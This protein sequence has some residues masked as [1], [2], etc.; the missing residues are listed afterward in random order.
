M[1]YGCTRTIR[2]R[3]SNRRGAA[4]LLA[5]YF[6]SLMF[7]LLGGV[8]LQRTMTETK[9]AYLSRDAHQSFWSA[10][11]AFDQAL[12]ALRANE[13]PAFDALGCTYQTIQFDKSIDARGNYM[14]CRT[15]NPEQFQVDMLGTSAT[16]SPVWLTSFIERKAPQVT[17]THAL[18]GLD[19]L[20]LSHATV[21]GLNTNT[22]PIALSASSLA[23][24]LFDGYTPKLIGT[25]NNQGHIA[26]KA[27]TREA[28]K[29][30]NN[31]NILGKILTG[32]AGVSMIS[33]DSRNQD[34]SVAGSVSNTLVDFPSVKTPETVPTLGDV[35]LAN[36]DTRPYTVVSATGAVTLENAWAVVAP[37]VYRTNGLIL[38]DASLSTNG[39]VD[40]YVK[41]S[42]TVTRSLLY[43]QALC[44]GQVPCPESEVNRLKFSPPNLRIYVQPV[45]ASDKVRVTKGAVVA[46]ILYAPQ[47]P[48]RIDRK[49][50]LM[51]AMVSKTAHIG[52]MPDEPFSYTE[53]AADKTQ[54]Y[55]DQAVG[56]QPISPSLDSPAAKVL[57]YSVHKSLAEASA[58]TGQDQNRV[59]KWFQF[60]NLIAPIVAA[61]AARSSP[62]SSGV[63]SGGGCGGGGGTIICTELHR[64]GYLSDARFAADTAY[65]KTYLDS[66]TWIGY[67][68]WAQYVA[69]GMRRSAFV[70]AL[71]RPFGLAWAQHMAFVMGEST[72][73]NLLGRVINDVGIPL[74]RAFGKYLVSL[75]RPPTQC[76]VP[77]A[78][79]WPEASAYHTYQF[80]SATNYSAWAQW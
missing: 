22:A 39:P 2:H 27:M 15:T 50:L 65:G 31:S 7:L 38:T 10:E 69:A 70:T 61:P 57:Y 44:P 62:G 4:F 45:G 24:D 54:V 37:G 40:L 48:V 71:V 60:A 16:S 23:K 52:L 63:S 43:G 35:L 11:A 20:V 47:M 49:S 34:T 67:H 36:P 74:N 77:K 32:T 12:I 46:G 33:A 58:L 6:A 13:L 28:L 66:D 14:I 75:R 18:V 29:V 55:Y 1:G 3:L 21:G 72:E 42:L 76:A 19:E 64:Q 41:G 79:E 53:A 73:D 8:S 5:V 51:G 9:A 80:P 30:L 25:Y 26:T 78:P 68:T 56:E 59:I 17:L